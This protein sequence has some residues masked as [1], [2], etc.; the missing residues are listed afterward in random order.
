M[1]GLAFCQVPGN[2][3]GPVR[4]T[5]KRDRAAGAACRDVGGIVGEGESAQRT[6]HEMREGRRSFAG[7]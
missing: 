6:P 5:L 4:W 7:G 1:A 2:A 3:A